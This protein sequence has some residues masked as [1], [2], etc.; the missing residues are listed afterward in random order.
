MARSDDLAPLL[1]AS[2]GPAVG[3]RQGVI[4][5]WDPDTAENTV[6]VGGALLENLNVLNTSEAAILAAGDVVGILTLP[7]TWAIIG[8]LTIPG[9]P[10]AVSSIQAI[11]NRIK[12]SADSGVGTRNSTAWGDL[13]GAEVGPSVEIRIGSS[14]RALVFW[15]AEIGQTGVN[16]QYKNNPHVGVEVSGASTESAVDGY[17][18]NYHFEFP[19]APTAGTAQMRSWIQFSTFHLFTGLN[20]GD[21]TFTLKYRHDTIDPA[22]AVSFNNREIAVFAL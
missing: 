16:F 8:R 2:P 18:L 1:A 14:G 11:T 7:G 3:Y 22:G 19:V 13:T 10:E 9:T 12:A 15:G 4:V 5:T 6:S 17:A 20:A 21:T